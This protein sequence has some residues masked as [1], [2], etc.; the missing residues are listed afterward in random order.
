MSS[1][2]HQKNFGRSFE[3][4]ILSY[5]NKCQGYSGLFENK[6]IPTHENILLIFSDLGA[7]YISCTRFMY[8]LLLAARIDALD[9]D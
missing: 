9:R 1:F 7:N 3:S 8:H 5:I 4:K 6:R 2:R